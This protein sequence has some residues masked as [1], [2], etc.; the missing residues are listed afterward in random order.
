MERAALTETTLGATSLINIIGS[1][2]TAAVVDR[3]DRP[4]PD[5]P[6]SN[7]VPSLDQL[8]MDARAAEE[9]IAD[10]EQT[11]KRTA[12]T[13]LFENSDQAQR[14]EAAVERGQ[15]LVHICSSGWN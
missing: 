5:V 4:G 2:A 12:E 3:N 11:K 9:R 10:L 13:L 8:V 14:I 6:R 15:V 1:A 7:N